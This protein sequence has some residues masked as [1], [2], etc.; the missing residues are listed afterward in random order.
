MHVVDRVETV[1]RITG[2]RYATRYAYHHGYFDGEDR[3][4]RGF[5]MVEHWDSSVLPTLGEPAA[6]LDPAAHLPPAM[7]RTWYH[8]GA[9]LNDGGLS[10]V[11]AREYHSE[12]AGSAA[13]LLP[14]TVLPTTLLSPT[15]RQP[16]ELTAAEARE[17]CR[18]MAGALLRQEVYAVDGTDAEERPYTV[19]ERSYAVELHQRAAGDRAAVCSVHPREQLDVHYE[20]VLVEVG[21][22]W[23]AD[24]RMTHTLTLEVDAFGAV[25]RAASV[26]YRRRDLPG[27][28]PEQRDTQV[29]LRTARVVH[30][31]GEAGVYRLGLPVQAR[32]FEVVGLPGPVIEDTR[33]LPYRF[34][35][36]AEL[37]E[38]MFPLAA[39]A[40]DPARL[41]PHEQWDWRATPPPS[42]RLRPLTELRT[43]YRQ[44]DL[45]GTLPFGMAGS[46]GLVEQ[47]FALALTAG[48]L[49]TVMRRS[50]AEPLVGDP[51]VLTGTGA[52]QG[53]YT[54]MEGGWWVP[55]GRVRFSDT[56]DLADPGATAASELARARAHFFRP[57][58]QADPFGRIT[59]IAYDDADLLP[60]ATEDAAGQIWTAANDYRV[61]QPY[62]LT[63]P[64]GNRSVVAFDALGMVAASAVQGKVGQADGDDVSGVDTDPPTAARQNLAAD[65]HAFA[66]GLLGPASERTVYDVDR[67]RRCGR[68]AVAIG[69]ARTV[70]TG[71][72]GGAACPLTVSLTFSDGSGQQIQ[73]KVQAEP[74]EAPLRGP[75]EVTPS[76]DTVPGP[77]LRGPDGV[78]LLGPVA[79]RWVGTGRVV[80]NN[81]GKP[82][83]HYQPFFSATPLHEP[84]AD[85]TG[86]G[87]SPVYFYDPL[88]RV[89]ATVHPERTYSKVVFDPWRQVSSD[90]N[91]TTTDDPR[92]DPDTA[93]YVAAFFAAQ[94]PGWQTWHAARAGGA[95]GDDELDAARKTEAHAHTPGVLHVDPA[96]RAVRTI[97]HNRFE[98]AGVTVEELIETR[99]VIDGAGLVRRIVNGLGRTVMRYSYDAQGERIHQAGAESGA[100]WMLADAGGQPIRAWDDQGRRFRSEYDDLRRPVAH[101]VLGADPAVP[102][103]EILVERIVHGDSPLT[104][105]TRTQA[106]DRNL[107]THVHQHFD[108]AGVVIN[109]VYDFTGNLLRGIRRLVTGYAVVPDWGKAVPPALDEPMVVGLA[110]DARGRAVSYTAPDG[111]VVLPQYNEAGLLER[112]GVRRPGAAAATGFVT[113]I[114]YDARG[115]RTVVEYANSARTTNEFDPLTSRTTRSRTT[116]PGGLDAL[117]STIFADPTVVQ[118]LR[119]VYD[120]AGNLTRCTDAALAVVFHDNQRIEPVCDYTHDAAYRLVAATGREQ[121]GQAALDLSPPPGRSRRDWPFAGASAHP[122]D[123]R[124]LRGYTERY[125]YDQAG[126]LTALRHGAQWTR[127]YVYAE[128]SLLEPGQL[129]NR[130]TRTTV[131]GSTETYG[132][133]TAGAVTSLNS[134]GLTWDYA[135]RLRRVDLGGGGVAHYVYDSAG[136][137]VRTVI[138][139]NGAPAVERVYGGGFERYR[140]FGI[141]GVRL[142]RITLHVLD[143]QRR[144]ALV[145]TQTVADG[146][147]LP[148]PAAVIRYQF[149]NHLGSA[150]LE[151][152]VLARVISYEEFHPF[153]TSAF[154]VG[155]AGAEVGLKRYRFTGRER[156]DETGFAMHGARYYA[157]WLGRWIS[158]DPIGTG[159]GVNLYA[160]A[161]NQ[162]VTATDPSGQSGWTKVENEDT[163]ADYYYHP[164]TELGIRKSAV[165]TEVWHYVSPKEADLVVMKFDNDEIKGYTKPPDPK[166]VTKD[167]KTIAPQ[168]FQDKYGVGSMDYGKL[169]EALIPP[170]EPLYI[171]ED[172]T[173][174]MGNGGM[175]GTSDALDE[176]DLGNRIAGLQQPTI[177]GSLYGVAAVALG[178]DAKEAAKMIN[179]GNAMDKMVQA[180]IGAAAML[181]S[182]PGAGPGAGSG[183]SDKGWRPLPPGPPKDS[184]AGKRHLPLVNPHRSDNRPQ[185]RI[186]GATENVA[187][188]L[189]ANKPLINRYLTPSESKLA[190]LGPWAQRIVFGNAV[191]RA[192]AEGSRPTGLLTHTGDIR[193]APRGGPDLTG[194]PGTPFEGMLVQI[195]SEKGYWTHAGK[196]DPATTWGLYPGYQP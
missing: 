25:P 74:G 155:P 79:G 139:R 28:L 95:L 134:M 174:Y 42:P 19:S 101:H 26:A 54:A 123:L 20:R 62:R 97:A 96:G 52:D 17:A 156:D 171:P 49:D 18:A 22:R 114:N 43:L 61:L 191:E 132:Y 63:D 136:R 83:R 69:L 147:V 91:D 103:R 85:L 159:D 30:R 108:S 175:V 138:E 38:Q 87:V 146:A 167:I 144:I 115:R 4:F 192:L 12:D 94:P 121:V 158:A 102:G 92:T 117:G 185:D 127:E 46:R 76:G 157:P 56:A 110:Y 183:S 40:P 98:R 113:G 11:Y 163:S 166:V 55:S 111:S 105:L 186:Q 24:P 31:P 23:R 71:E 39:D 89:V 5:G 59:R 10:E 154:Q 122:N 66:A 148:A 77:L 106:R 109:D 160:Y 187:A 161:H 58:L 78:P 1:D 143:G 152:D 3:E 170:P 8:T 99:T 90:A 70:R 176:A 72:P 164:A 168:D 50:P 181:K 86:T 57:V 16:I 194:V 15:G 133:D 119:Y 177:T 64:N 29:L 37:V 6:N 51:S 172:K 150:A 188:K 195:T 145:E 2:N 65:P 75:D 178:G 125:D 9:F 141:G 182:R 35:E 107:L 130:L 131:A 33:V 196:V 36:L 104:G 180:G 100:R 135:Q 80:L 32:T 48:L 193:P 190:G 151:L 73:R 112:I 128:P 68:P 137:R 149:G 45:S 116:R 126:N 189:Q 41:W 179:I 173:L 13:P 169:A 60:V 120:P 53:G 81:K 67:Y 153:G 124:A 47:S 84:E 82:V 184:G 14:D 93:P 7:T 21:G 88:A 140:E 162:P 118:D 44:D 165:A 34:E 27:V 129:G 142:E